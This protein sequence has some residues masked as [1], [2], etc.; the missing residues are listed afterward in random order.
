[1][2]R[3]QLVLGIELLEFPI[4]YIPTVAAEWKSN[5]CDKTLETELGSQNTNLGQVTCC[6][7]RC[8]RH[9]DL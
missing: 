6:H 8:V 5:V 7:I 4:R 9:T 3:A 2:F 1:M